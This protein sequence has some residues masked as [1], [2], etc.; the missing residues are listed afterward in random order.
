MRRRG[1]VVE[2]DAHRGFG[3][4]E[5]EDGAR[6]MFHCTQIVDESRSIAVG[7]IVGFDVVPGHAGAWEAS[8][9]EVAAI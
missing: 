1:R 8:S 2:F 6:V 9:V 3:L 4:I 5:A 7:E